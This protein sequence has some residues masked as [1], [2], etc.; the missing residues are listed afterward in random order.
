MDAQSTTSVPSAV[1][2]ELRLETEAAERELAQLNA[3]DPDVVLA[4]DYVSGALSPEEHAVFEARM[5]RDE[6]LQGLVLPLLHLR[7]AMRDQHDKAVEDGEPA[8]RLALQ[9]LR[10]RM[11]QS[12]G[13][14]YDDD[15]DARASSAGEG[16]RRSADAAAAQGQRIAR[17]AVRVAGALALLLVSIYLL[18]LFGPWS[19]LTPGWR[20][21]RDEEALDGTL[22]LRHEVRVYTMGPYFVAEY[23]PGLL[24]TGDWFDSVSELYVDAPF[25][26]VSGPANG[27]RDIRVTTPHLR[28]LSQGGLMRVDLENACEVKVTAR[29][30]QLLVSSRRTAAAEPAVVQEGQSVRMDCDGSLGIPGNAQRR[31]TTPP[32][33]N[34]GTP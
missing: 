32:S 5:A 29:S 1:D 4:M 16:K 14:D 13:D 21:M 12:N 19:P 2:W 15:R 27:R 7:Q 31:T 8:A 23:T 26:S 34:G 3:S 10:E 25:F 11:L 33:G 28:I 6:K 9:R 17:Y 24:N 20:V 18:S 22:A 30:G